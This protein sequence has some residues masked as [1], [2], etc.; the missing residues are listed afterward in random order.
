MNS[1]IVTAGSRA[2]ITPSELDNKW[3]RGARQVKIGIDK[4]RSNCYSHESWNINAVYCF[5]VEWNVVEKFVVCLE[6][7]RKKVECRRWIKEKI[8]KKKKRYERDKFYRDFVNLLIIKR[9]V[10]Q[11]V[12]YLW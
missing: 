9:K 2:I 12:D 4:S 8:K 5:F 1:A 10:E 6:E 3:R 11:N 7:E